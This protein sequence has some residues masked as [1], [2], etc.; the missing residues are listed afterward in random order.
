MTAPVT[1]A[2]F[3]PTIGAEVLRRNTRAMLVAIAIYAVFVVW[4]TVLFLGPTPSEMPLWLTILVW[5]SVLA[6]VLGYLAFARRGIARQTNGELRDGRV[7]ALAV[8]LTG[9]RLPFGEEL[10]WDTITS[11]SVVDISGRA[12]SGYGPRPLGAR[13]GRYVVAGLGIGSRTLVVVLNDGAGF[14]ASMVHRSHRKRVTLFDRADGS[15]GGYIT[16]Y[17]DPLAPTVEVDAALDVL[18]AASREHGIP[19]TRELQYRR[20]AVAIPAEARLP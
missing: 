3:D 7:T 4:S 18:E 8:S 14:A 1:E 5:T 19:F 15:T 11:L 13:L 10:P 6:L 20:T 16:L 2:R 12:D 17:L 9:L